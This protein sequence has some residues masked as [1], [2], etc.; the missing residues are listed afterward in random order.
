MVKSPTSTFALL[1]FILEIVVSD[2]HFREGHFRDESN[3]ISKSFVGPLDPTKSLQTVEE[4]D[5]FANVVPKMEEIAFSAYWNLP[6]YECLDKFGIDLQL[7]KFGI[8]SNANGSKTGDALVLFSQLVFGVYPHFDKYTKVP[9]NGGLPQLGNLTQH[10]EKAAQDIVSAIPNANFSGLAIIDWELWHPS[11]DQNLLAGII[12]CHKSLDLVQKNHPDWSS[13]QVEL[14]ARIEFEEAA[15]SYLESTLSLVKRLRPGARLGFY[16]YPACY[17][18]YTES[19]ACNPKAILTNDKLKWLFADCTALYPSIY[20]YG[21]RSDY[22]TYVE[23]NIK[24]ALRV[25]KISNVSQVPI[26]AYSRFNYSHS[27]LYYTKADLNNTILQAAELGT[28]GVIFWGDHNDTHSLQSCLQLE[29]YLNTFLGPFVKEVVDAASLCS[30]VT[31]SGHGRCIGDI[32][33][34]ST[35][36]AGKSSDS[37][38]NNAYKHGTQCTCSCYEGWQSP[39]CAE[40]PTIRER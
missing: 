27:G 10:L 34:C 18:R 39:S 15:R 21:S 4:E 6:T 23:S 37:K 14:V 30:K 36:G 16:H 2:S 28:N 40:Q 33:G 1:I 32:I 26:F 22:H 38:V 31:C 20:L 8:T 17:N 13:D 9:V 7:G 5:V 11:W 19:N 35:S 25:R 3:A 29:S 24:E 12:Y